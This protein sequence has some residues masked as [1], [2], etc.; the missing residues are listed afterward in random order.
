VPYLRRRDGHHW[1]AAATAAA[2][3]AAAAVETFD[4]VISDIGL[5]DR[6]GTELMKEL[7]STYRLRGVALTGYGM[8]DDLLSA[9][10]AGFI[11]HLVKPV[12]VAELRRVIA[13]LPDPSAAAQ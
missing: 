11:H 6:N 8:E 13:S 4:Y 1:V 5:P 10:D 12:S 9:R 2:A 3:L 7:R